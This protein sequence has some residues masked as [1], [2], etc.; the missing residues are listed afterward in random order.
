MAWEM[1]PPTGYVAVA[2]LEVDAVQ[3]QSG[4]FVMRGV[5]ADSADY[6]ME[7][8][9]DMPID[10]RTQAVLGEILSQSEWQLWRKARQPLRARVRRSPRTD[11]NVQDASADG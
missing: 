10:R 11:A 7:L 1:T 8:H 6:V 5:G 4:G 2:S 9:L 3:P